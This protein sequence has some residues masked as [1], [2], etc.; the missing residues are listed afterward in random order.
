MDFRRAA[1]A[2]AANGLVVRPPFLAAL[3][4]RCALT[5]ELSIIATTGG[6][7]HSTRAANIF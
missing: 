2:R 4:E 6:P 1:A 3:A 7:E 5:A